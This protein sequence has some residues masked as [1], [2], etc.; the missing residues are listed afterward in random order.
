ML[1]NPKGSPLLHFRHY[2]TFSERKES[3]KFKFFSKKVFCAFWALDI[4]PTLNVPVL[5]I[6][7]S[8]HGTHI[9]ICVKI[10][11]V[12]RII[13][14]LLLYGN[15]SFMQMCPYKV[16]G[17]LTANSLHWSALRVA[18]ICL[19]KGLEEHSVN[20]LRN[21]IALSESSSK[22]ILFLLKQKTRKIEKKY[23]KNRYLSEIGSL[24]FFFDCEM[25]TKLQVVILVSWHFSEVKR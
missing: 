4:A 2:A 7:W 5:F 25:E 17:L 10:R 15:K 23:G 3:K 12:G 18:F 9:F 20:N 19:R 11:Y 8:F 24:Q 14:L 1:L 13:C 22:L 6:L 21:R 16:I